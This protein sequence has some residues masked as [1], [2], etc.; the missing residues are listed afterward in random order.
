MDRSVPTLPKVR[1][2]D[3]PVQIPVANH[4]VVGKTTGVS[5]VAC[6]LTA[7]PKVTVTTLMTRIEFITSLRI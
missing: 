3:Q 2:S 5:S 1:V 6:T 7:I 4:P